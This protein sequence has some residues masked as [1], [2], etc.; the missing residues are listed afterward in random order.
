MSIV[1]SAINWKGHFTNDNIMVAWNLTYVL[2]N[3][4][5]ILTYF[6]V[7]KEFVYEVRSNLLGRDKDVWEKHVDEIVHYIKEDD[8]FAEVEEDYDPT[9]WK[10]FILKWT[11]GDPQPD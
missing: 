8:E 1:Y 4:G 10:G 9:T 6:T 2:Q 7:A 5:L 11:I 3:L